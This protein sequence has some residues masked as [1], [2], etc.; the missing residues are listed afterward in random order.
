[1]LMVLRN[2]NSY[3]F[4]KNASFYEK[5]KSTNVISNYLDR[6]VPAGKI[7]MVVVQTFYSDPVHLQTTLSLPCSHS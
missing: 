6:Q 7:D 2:L 4:S 5:I 1:M 3:P